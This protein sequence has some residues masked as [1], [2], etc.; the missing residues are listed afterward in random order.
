[1]KKLDK[2]L[3]FIFRTGKGRV[4]LSSAIVFGAASLSGC[5]VWRDMACMWN[6]LGCTDCADSC[7]DCDDSSCKSCDGCGF[8]DCIFGTACATDNDNCEGFSCDEKGCTYNGHGYVCTGCGGCDSVVGGEKYTY[9]LDISLTVVDQNG[10]ILYEGGRTHEETKD[11]PVGFETYTYDF[12]S[13]FGF[14]SFTIEKVEVDGK[15]AGKST[16]V[17]IKPSWD[18]FNAQSKVEVKVSENRVGEQ[19]NI[20]VTYPDDTETTYPFQI[21]GAIPQINV[22]TIEGYVF[23]GFY[24]TDAQ[25]NSHK[26]EFT[27]GKAFHLYDYSGILSATGSSATVE[28]RYRAEQFSVKVI[29]VKNGNIAET[30]IINGCTVEMTLEEV[31]NKAKEN[32]NYGNDFVDSTFEDWAFDQEGTESITSSD[33]A[34]K[35]SKGTTVYA[36]YKKNSFT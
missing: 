16:S 20:I 13:S 11:A 26:L 7:E 33:K 29:L 25:Q 22:K 32:F 10:E 6:C 27:A 12:G 5:F 3:N 30:N 9:K 21:G 2:F 28:A 24:I 36:I 4:L 17:T 34:K 1:M 19:Y 31:L 14:S 18:K 35:A 15:E 23:D 8:M